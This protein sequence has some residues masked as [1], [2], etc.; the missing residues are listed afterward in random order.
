MRTSI[1]LDNPIVLL[2][3]RAPRM[4]ASHGHP[5]DGP[6]PAGQFPLRLAGAG[7]WVTITDFCGRRRF[8]D[9]L[10]GMGLHVGARIQVLRNSMNGK[11]L[12]GHA[13]TRLFLGGGMAHKI[14]VTRTEGEKR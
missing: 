12:I 11:L 9:R 8:T 4:T 14:R 2:A 13:G 1:V 10:A 3:D 5:G 7:E 6:S